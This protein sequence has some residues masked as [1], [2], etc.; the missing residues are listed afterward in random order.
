MMEVWKDIKD[1][2]GFYQISSNGRV[3]SLSRTYTTRVGV[4]NQTGFCK[5]VDK[6]IV[7]SEKILVPGKRIHGYLFNT[8][9]KDL[10]HKG[11]DIHRLVAN[12][13]LPNLYN[14]PEVNHINGVKSN[15]HSTNLEW[16]TRKENIEHA[17]KNN[18]YS[19]GKQHYRFNKGYL[20]EGEK[21]HRAILT[22][23]IVLDI[24]F[25]LDQEVLGV[26]IAKLYNTSCQN[27][28]DIKLKRRWKH[29]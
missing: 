21:N 23:D 16:C 7:L 3:K 25:L 11:K 1:Y 27:I 26:K 12:A 6:V 20:Q 2:E 9:C 29:I 22:K 14:K 5:T 17:I 8:L 24:R 28:S 10:H 4:V 15:N 19:T 18:L 13:F